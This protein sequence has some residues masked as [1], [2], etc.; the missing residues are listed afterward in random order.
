MS[1]SEL[2]IKNLS[3]KVDESLIKDLV[4][5]YN[6]IKKFHQN[7]KYNEAINEFGKFCETVFQILNFVLKNEKLGEI[8]NMQNMIT[9]FENSRGEESLRLII[10]RIVYATYTLRSKR[11]AA[12]KKEGIDPNYIDSSYVA[13]TCDWIIAE[14]LRLFHT[15]DL[16]NVRILI[17][18]LME[19]NI[20]LIENFG[21]D[22]IIL[23]NRFKTKDKILIYL[24]DSY[25]SYLNIKTLKRW[26]K[27]KYPQELTS[28]LGN[29]TKEN[30]V[31][32]NKDLCI[33]TK[34]GIKFVEDK[35]DFFFKEG[36]L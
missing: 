35:H 24:F 23:N 20:P 36:I 34:K 17:Q 15:E 1:K 19:K 14:I 16:E 26:I 33:L 12:H 29:L 28:N 25:P 9:I 5:R 3:S 30:L 27:P 31:Y 6:Y 7:G 8:K 13:S 22:K 10:P 2:I 11:G 4:N 18:E 21:E 32:K